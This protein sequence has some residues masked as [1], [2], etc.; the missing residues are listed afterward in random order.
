[1]VLIKVY[2]RFIRFILK[3]SCGREEINMDKLRDIVNYAYKNVDY[4]H[5]LYKNINFN[6]PNFFEEIPLLHKK[7]V[8]NQLSQFISKEYDIRDLLKENTSGS[9]GQTLTIYK[10][11]TERIKADLNLWKMRKKY[12]KD[13]LNAKI[14][15][16]Y[17]YRR[18][19]NC[20][21]SDPVYFNGNEINLS[22]FDLSDEKLF[23]YTEIIKSVEKCW[24]FAAPS[25]MLI[26]ANFLKKNNI[27]LTNVAFVELTGEMVTKQQEAYISE[28]FNCACANHYGSREFWGVAYECN[29]GNLHI[30]DDYVYVEVVDEHGNNLGYNQ[31]GYLCYTGLEKYSMPLIRYIQGDIGYI[32][33]SD[34]QCGLT[35]DILCLSGGRVTEYI[36]T[37]RG[38]TVN[39][40]VLF[41]II[42]IINK[43]TTNILQF[44]FIQKAYNV[45]D[46]CIVL[47]N[48]NVDKS[49]IVNQ[50]RE[51]M[52]HY[53][54]TFISLNVEFV[55]KVEFNK[56]SKK[57]KYFINQLSSKSIPS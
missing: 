49:A 14:I 2:M 40:M 46:A 20:L 18:K 8:Q 32:K 11:K 31:E 9:S 27:A 55:D 48:Q 47:A 23:E 7:E 38:E 41:F 29:C 50:L 53:L 36:S 44:Q 56:I 21:I 28:C 33:K 26:Y 43:E 15:K 1:M 51:L 12:Y 37:Q 39:S 24:F 3:M 16:F 13:I 42:E 45:F 4:Y 57:H 6:R 25:V 17:A 22:L 52:S 54:K 10:D 19:D 35:S 34:C 5:E 30:F